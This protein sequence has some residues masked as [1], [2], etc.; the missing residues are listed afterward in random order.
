MAGIDDLFKGNVITGLAVGVGVAILAPVVLPVVAAVVRPL[1]K[2][3][4]KTGIILYEQGLETVAELG[5]VV[6]DLVAEAKA[7]IATAAAPAVAAGAAA[8]G[9][10]ASAPEEGQAHP[11]EPKK[12]ARRTSRARTAGEPPAPT[13]TP[14]SEVPESG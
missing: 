10:T 9:G 7:E 14:G 5:E 11:A 1:A 8:A 13:S 3:A 2:S 4:I 6:D 12:A